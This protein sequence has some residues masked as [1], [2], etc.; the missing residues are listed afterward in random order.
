[1]QLVHIIPV[2]P[3]MQVWQFIGQLKH[4]LFTIYWAGEQLDRHVL[5]IGWYKYP[6]KHVKHTILLV[7]V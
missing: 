7:Q 6:F 5:L 4:V 2:F 1:V 3:E